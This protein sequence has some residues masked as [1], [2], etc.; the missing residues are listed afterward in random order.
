MLCEYLSESD[1]P[2]GCSDQSSSVTA[3][4]WH[5]GFPLHIRRSVL[6]ALPFTLR[7]KLCCPLPNVSKT[8]V[9][10]HSSSL[11]SCC[12]C[13]W[14]FQNYRKYFKTCARGKK[15]EPFIPYTFLFVHV[16]VKL[17]SM[18]L[19][20]P[21]TTNEYGTT[22]SNSHA[23]ETFIFRLFL[24]LSCL[25]NKSHAITPDPWRN[26]CYRKMLRWVS[27]DSKLTSIR[28]AIVCLACVLP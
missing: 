27:I 3:R 21:S 9:R 14:Q 23:R 2:P 8:K 15:N 25:P 19:Q 6:S 11:L 10:I 26:R 24:T 22:V 18:V 17:A 20:K 28:I 7:W 5:R 16:L 13:H 4:V 12:P 1:I